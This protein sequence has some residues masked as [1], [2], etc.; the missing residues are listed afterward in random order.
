VTVTRVPRPGEGDGRRGAAVR[1]M[2][3]RIAPT[4]D[5][6][7]RVLALRTDVRWRRRLVAT[8]ALGPGA[9]VVDLCAGTLDVAVAV[10]RAHPPA[11]VVGADFAR[12]MLRAGR[13][14]T[15]LPAA[16]ADALA[17]PFRAASC[18]A[19]TVA[20]GVRNLESLEAGLAEIARVLRP[21]GQVAVL[22]LFR[23]R[24]AGARAVH[25]LYNRA[26]V[27]LLGRAVSRDP[28]AYRYL[29][30]SIEAF[31]GADEFAALLARAGFSDVRFRTLW[32]G[33]AAIV[34][35]RRRDEAAVGD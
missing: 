21:G 19:C 31:V 4:Y 16:Q 30:D 6:L 11:R 35:G 33:A 22:E 28:D 2:F 27:P 26:L 3:D 29:V 5:L 8:L 1:Q 12:A 23:P 25:A 18:D 10:R 15:G 17:L 20:F 13:R 9:R 34:W 7:N 24:G 14:K 32:P